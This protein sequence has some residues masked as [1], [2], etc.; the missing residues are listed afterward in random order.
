[1]SVILTRSASYPLGSNT[2]GVS[3][4][5]Q[6]Q[7]KYYSKT[8]TTGTTQ[9]S[10]YLPDTSNVGVM[11]VPTGGAAQV[12]FTTDPVDVV[13]TGTPTWV[14]GTPGS[15]TVA[16]FASITGPTAI[17]VNMTAAT[18]CKITVRC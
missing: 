1:M 16:T 17:R 18:S 12:E 7:Y 2:A 3:T 6:P 5:A 14:I 9:E 11:I 13:E 4:T 8:Y 10:I 15:V